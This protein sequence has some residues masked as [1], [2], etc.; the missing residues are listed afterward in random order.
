MGGGGTISTSDTKVDTLKISSS[1]YGVAIPLVWGKTRISMN[2]LDYIDFTAIP[3]TTTTN[4]GGKGGGGVKQQN[5]TYTYT[6]AL[7]MLLCEG[8]IDSIDNVWVGKNTTELDTANLSLFTGTR[9]QTPWDYMT[10]K[11]PERALSYAGM[12][13]VA[14]VFDLGDDANLPNFT[15]EVTSKIG[16]AAVDVPDAHPKEI[17]TDFLT[18]S[19]YGVGFPA[20]NIGNWTQFERYCTANSIFLSPALVE[21]VEAREFINEVATATNSAAVWSEGLLKM[22]PYGDATMTGNGVTFTPDITPLY[23]LTDDDFLSEDGDDPVTIVRDTATDAYNSISVEF[24]NRDNQYN[25]EI[26]NA[27]DIVDIEDKGLRPADPIRMHSICNRTT[28]RS[29]AQLRLQRSLYVRNRFEFRLGWKYCLLEPMDVVTL[30]DAYLGLDRQLVRIVEKEEDEWG[31]F[32]FIAEEM[33][34]GAAASPLYASQTSGGATVNRMVAAGNVVNPVIFN[35]P[36]PLA[37]G[38]MEIWMGA[39][40]GEYWGGCEVWISEDNATYKYVGSIN[41]RGRVGTL[42]EALATSLVSPD[43]SH[44]LKVNL[45]GMG[46]QLLTGTQSDADSLQ[47]LM[48]VDGEFM[49]Y[50]TATLTGINAYN[51]TY[52][53]R[54]AYNTQIKSHN[55][56][57]KFARLDDALFKYPFAKTDI[58]K[59]IYV[60]MLSFNIYGG[61][62]Q[63]LSDV[64]AVPYTIEYPLPPNVANITLDE[65]TFILKDGTVLSDIL[66]NFDGIET[67]YEYFNYYRVYYDLNNSGS[68][69]FAGTATSSGYTLK[70]LPNTK[71]VKVKVVTVN[72]SLMESVGTVSGSYTLTGKSNPPDSVTVFNAVAN[73]MDNTEVL[74]TWDAVDY[75]ANPDVKGYEIRVGSSW[76]GGTPIGAIV[77]GTSAK[78]KAQA[79][80]SYKFWICAIDWSNNYSS[81]PKDATCSV[82]ITPDTPLVATAVQDPNDRTAVLISW[83]AIAQKDIQF[84]EI[85]LNSDTGTLLGTTKELQFKW[86]PPASSVSG[87]TFAI[88]AKNVADKWGIAKTASTPA[89]CN[90]EPPNVSGFVYEQTPTDRSKVRLLWGKSTDLDV[91]YYEIRSSDANWG[92]TTQVGNLV[93]TRITG[94]FYD[95]IASQGDKDWFI[96][97]VNVGGKYSVDAAE[98]GGY[99][100]LSPDEPDS[101]DADRAEDDRSIINFTWAG[102]AQQDLKEYEVQ[103]AAVN[104]ATV[105]DA[106]GNTVIKTKELK[107]VH[108]PT[109]SGNYTY[110]IKARAHSGATSNAVSFP[111]YATLEPADMTSLQASQNGAN[112]LLIWEKHPEPDV[113]GYEIRE[114]NSFESGSLIATGLTGTKY[115]TPVDTERKWNFHIKAINRA[116][117]YSS[118][119]TSAS[120]EVA[121]LPPKNVVATYDELNDALLKAAG[122]HTGTEFGT[123]TINFQNLGGRF[124][125]YPSTRFSDVGGQMVL[126]LAPELL[127]ENKCGTEGGTASTDWTQWSHFNDQYWK[128]GTYSQITNGS[129]G[130][131]GNVFVG[132]PYGS[133]GAAILYDYFHYTFKANVLYK[134]SILVKGAAAYN[135]K[136]LTA[137][138]CDNVSGQAWRQVA[139]ANNSKTINVS[140][141]WQR[142]EFEVMYSVDVNGVGGIGINIGTGWAGT[143]VL[144]F[145]KPQFCEATQMTRWTANKR[146][147]TTKNGIPAANL[148]FANWNAYQG[149]VVTLTQNQT[150]A[151]WATDKAT[152]IQTSGGT[153]T[154]KYYIGSGS[155]DLLTKHSTSVKVKN[156]GTATVRVHGQGGT[157]VDVL[158][159]ETKLCKNEGYAA[160]GGS[161]V[162]LRFSGYNI[163]DSL[164]FYAFEPQIEEWDVATNCISDGSTVVMDY[165]DT[166][167]YLMGRKDMGQVITA[168]IASQFSTSIINSAGTGA[169]LQ[170]RLSTDGS[171]FTDWADFVPVEA[172]FQFIDLRAVLTSSDA[173]KTPEVSLL[174]LNVDVPDHDE[175]GTADIAMGGEAVGY[176]GWQYSMSAV[177]LPTAVGTNPATGNPLRADLVSVGLGSATVKVRDAVTG[178][179]VG[180]QIVWQSRGY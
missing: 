2:L 47:T 44:T 173:T 162:Q 27:D 180:G 113:T 57:T 93:A 176:N 171:T 19:T 149:A 170:Y 38:G 134:I 146:Y 84:Y 105:W 106:V 9:P 99:I 124:S 165:C 98:C 65:N 11:H 4:S 151:E 41:T 94:I 6:T 15:F 40:G 52:L 25:I 78:Y 33:T 31:T 73:E 156:I 13:Y 5:T 8:E 154:M 153:H 39:T 164:D 128:A 59:T 148:N 144:Y 121:N 167:T 51:L 60:K 29:V 17:L 158:A 161:S 118:G 127:T 130:Q 126:R 109:M 172:T 96:K 122:T 68:W 32:T 36:E 135:G 80:Q 58:G 12:A 55:A 34:V 43:T 67:A 108:R 54:G 75:V 133:S 160:G 16:A 90:I 87:Y 159:G 69:T 142:V 82:K 95:L 138:L 129:Q 24:L 166:G 131:V 10:S 157:T 123:S 103:V 104:V 91:A 74:L 53:V 26:V 179:D 120:V 132:T 147:A 86:K 102:V 1:S 66:V 117:K 143:E 152:R 110:L 155:G 23:D 136:T 49:A 140:T 168:N 169:K 101:L 85:R 3:H 22:I 81:V 141:S 56:A 174:T 111:Y 28:A 150:V 175:Y 100:D 70:S 14:G 61:A 21:Q 125:D 7:A 83:D 139:L 89:P 50:Q 114:G 97:A 76:S 42:T 35:A 37:A 112:V 62:R 18:N 145:A 116:G 119:A 72:K 20:E 64:T 178:A 88:R 77:Y 30:T 177:F 79:T 163:A 92:S 71:S 107:A 115:Q 46:G 45:A 63:A 48:W 137:Y